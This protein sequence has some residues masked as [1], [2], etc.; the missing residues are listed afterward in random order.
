MKKTL[1]VFAVIGASLVLAVTAL[2]AA[3]AT[4]ADD[5]SGDHKVCTKTVM[6]KAAYDVVVKGTPSQWWN[7][8]PN[9]TKGPFEGPPAFPS[10]SRGTWQGPHT[11][12]G[13][14]GT[15]TYQMGNGHGSWFHREAATPDRTIH[16]AAT[17]KKVVVPCGEASTSVD[18]PRRTESA[19]VTSLP[20]TGA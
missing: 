10:D 7:W 11:N 1:H 18:V 20:Q 9:K 6:D 5:N 15:G 2:F 3:P 19:T 8:S 13:P 17:F 12:G 14:A 16:H 4:Q